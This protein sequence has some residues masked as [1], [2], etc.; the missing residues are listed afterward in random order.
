MATEALHPSIRPPSNFDARSNPFDVNGG[1]GLRIN[2]GGDLQ[3][4]Y[5]IGRFMQ[6]SPAGQANLSPNA[7]DHMP[8]GGWTN[9]KPGDENGSGCGCSV[10]SPGSSQGG[11][12]PAGD[13]WLIGLLFIPWIRRRT[14]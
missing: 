7:R 5:W 6:A 2:P 10:S 3:A 1:G 11:G 12:L 4:S 13:L 14:T 8:V 9:G